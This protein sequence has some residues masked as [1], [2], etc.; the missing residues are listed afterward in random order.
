MR[1]RMI[2]C[3]RN[4]VCRMAPWTGFQ[5]LALVCSLAFGRPVSAQTTVPNSDVGRTSDHQADMAELNCLIRDLSSVRS[6]DR[7]HS[8]EAL[9]ELGDK[10]AVEPL[11]KLLGDEDLSVREGAA[12]ALGELRDARAVQPLINV[13]GDENSVVQ[14][15]AAEALGKLGDVQAVEPLFKALGDADL[16]VR[17]SAT[18]ALSMLGDAQAVKLLPKSLRGEPPVVSQNAARTF[19][20]LLRPAKANQWAATLA[21]GAAFSL[22]LRAGTY[23]VGESHAITWNFL[24][25]CLEVL[26]SVPSLAYSGILWIVFALPGWLWVQRR[27]QTVPGIGGWLALGW[28]F[29][30]EALYGLILRWTLGT[31]VFLTLAMIPVWISLLIGI[32]LGLACWPKARQRV[33][34]FRCRDDFHRFVPGPRLGWMVRWSGRWF[35]RE[36]DAPK[37]MADSCVC[38]ACGKN[39]RYEGV[40]EV[41]AVLDNHGGY[42]PQ[43]RNAV[44]RVNWLEN[45]LPFDFDRVEVVDATDTE[46]EQFHRQMKYQA[47][48]QIQKR[49]P[50][51]QCVVNAQCRFE[52]ENTMTL[53]RQTFGAVERQ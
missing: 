14:R 34:G 27:Q 41:V 10:G 11:I 24:S 7:F 38:R 40:K 43:Q 44:L 46:V 6:S 9:G 13:L 52:R 53:L 17:E 16:S 50:K 23:L 42:Y 4:P 51:M 5:L 39:N 12:W 25:S 49:L 35:W 32:Y 18:R 48:P 8:A 26:F 19:S 20:R 28:G 30:V 2:T 22:R 1:Q 36:K 29:M 33:N 31:T 3:L 37:S 21:G 45:K 15:I 47:D